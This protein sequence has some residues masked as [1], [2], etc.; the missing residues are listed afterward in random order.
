MSIHYL[1]DIHSIYFAIKDNGHGIPEEMHSHVFEK[2]WQNEDF[3]TRVHGGSGMGL[4]LTQK[5]VAL[6]GGEINFNSAS[7]VGSTFYFTI[8]IQTMEEK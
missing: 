7:N 4:A 2:F 1:K 5:L 3:I 8:P 6:M